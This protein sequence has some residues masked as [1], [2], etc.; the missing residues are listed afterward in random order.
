[1][2]EFPNHVSILHAGTTALDVIFD[3]E[4][5]TEDPLRGTVGWVGPDGNVEGTGEAFSEPAIDA[6]DIVRTGGV[7]N[8]LGALARITSNESREAQQSAGLAITNAQRQIRETVVGIMARM[9]DD[10]AGERYR[11]L[12]HPAIDQSMITLIEGGK[13]GLSHVRL[14]GTEGGEVEKGTYAIRFRPGESGAWEP[15]EEDVERIRRCRPDCVNI[16]YPGLFPYGMDRWHGA[17]LSWFI[18]ELQKFCPMVGTDTHGPTE[19]HHIAPSLSHMDTMNVNMGNARKLFLA[20][21]SSSPLPA[22][23]EDQLQLLEQKLRAYMQRPT[24]RSRLFT[25]SHRCGT[26]VL[27]QSATGTIGSRHCLSPCAKINA[28]GG[29]VGAGDVQNGMEQ[30]YLI[31]EAGDVWKSGNVTIELA[32]LAATIG[33]IATTLHLQ[34]EEANAYDGVTMA[35]MEKVARSGQ[36]FHELH[37]L[38]QALLAS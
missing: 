27:C 25:V 37:D 21:E 32:S 13:S 24:G 19:L 15:T 11:T 29:T 17:R 9:G 6:A 2:G 26:F 7:A 38:R 4:D 33:Q 3:K 20:G 5:I 18:W 36:C 22:S 31:R 10:P 30:L 1:M 14:H 12:L 34:G 28:A 23:L 8:A 16:S 35:K